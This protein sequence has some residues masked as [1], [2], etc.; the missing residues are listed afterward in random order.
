M[1]RVNW[2]R[3][4]VDALAV[5]VFLLADAGC[6]RDPMR[7]QPKYETFEAAPFFADGTS[8]R[9]RIPGVVTIGDAL[10]GGM[11]KPAFDMPLLR[12][13]QERFNIFCSPCHGRDGMGRGMIV[14]RGYPQA[15]SLHEERLRQ[16][17]DEHLYAVIEK[18]I[19]K[20]P[21]YGASVEDRDRWAIVA[22]I[23][24]LQRTQHATRP[25]VPDAERGH[26][27]GE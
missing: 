22:Y 26:L 13:G 4:Q 23:R 20:M 27:E 17:P 14:Q 8:A 21:P 2:P 16:L 5:A 18:G 11:S 25:D 19:G 3:R 1:R 10:P 24:A 9:P 12:R 7:D 6:E 15:A